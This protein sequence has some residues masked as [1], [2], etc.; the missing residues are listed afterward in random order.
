MAFITIN[1]I[2][3]YYSDYF[4]TTPVESLLSGLSKNRF[5]LLADHPYIQL[6][7]F[8]ANKPIKRITLKNLHPMNKL[9]DGFE[10]HAWHQITTSISQFFDGTFNGARIEPSQVM[11]TLMRFG[12]HVMPRI[13]QEIERQIYLVRDKVKQTVHAE[14]R[15]DVSLLPIFDDVW[16]RMQAVYMDLSIVCASLVE[17][18]KGRAKDLVYEYFGRIVIKDDDIHDELIESIVR[19]LNETREAI[20]SSDVAAQV[21]R[22]QLKRLVDMFV[23]VKLYSISLEPAILTSTNT[24]Y[25]QQ[26]MSETAVFL[27]SVKETLQ[28]EEQ[29]AMELFPSSTLRP[30][31]HAVEQA[32]IKARLDQILGFLPNLFHGHGDALIASVYELVKRI[33]HLSQM[34]IAWHGVIKQVGI[35]IVLDKPNDQHMIDNLLTLRD[36]VDSLQNALNNDSGIQT[37]SKEAFEHFCNLRGNR[38]AELLAQHVD[39]I[40]R[41]SVKDVISDHELNVRLDRALVMFRYLQGKDV[42]EAF[43]KR[44]LARRLLL[45]RHAAMDVER[46]MLR[47]LQMECGSGFTSRMESMFKD[48]AISKEL[49]QHFRNVYPFYLFCSQ[50]S[51]R[52]NQSHWNSMSLLSQQASG[53]TLLP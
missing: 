33:D 34:Y 43:Y 41:Q 2:S 12:V 7:M 37:A 49:D 23:T 1:Y 53:L 18:G 30:L 20:Q 8:L 5:P 44:D 31:V 10:D 4:T 29:L 32:L 47:R 24:F 13:K 52:S 27:Q 51:S 17:E 45:G 36:Q 26:P 28:F 3:G 35:Q 46:G 38:P 21:K 50:S 11:E 42:F 48:M 15:S 40:L 6:T 22:T 14:G 16:V 9:P 25:Q 19:Q 39:T